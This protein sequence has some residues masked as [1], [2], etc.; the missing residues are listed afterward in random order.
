MLPA[1]LP[2]LRKPINRPKPK[3]KLR[4]TFPAVGDET[5]AEEEETFYE[6]RTKSFEH[7]HNAFRRERDGDLYEDDPEILLMFL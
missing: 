4:F 3:K 1:L 7:F 2:F 6:G 5:E